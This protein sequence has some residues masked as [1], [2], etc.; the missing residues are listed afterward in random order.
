[1]STESKSN[2]NLRK[3]RALHHGRGRMQKKFPKNDL[4]LAGFDPA[5]LECFTGKLHSVLTNYTKGPFV[6]VGGD[7]LFEILFL[8]VST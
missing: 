8:S 2:S 5:S 3:R 4:D 6:F 7:D 1:M